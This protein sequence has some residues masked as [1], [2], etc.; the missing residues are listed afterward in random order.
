MQVKEGQDPISSVLGS[1]TSEKRSPLVRTGINPG[2]KSIPA[3]LTGSPAFYIPTPLGFTGLRYTLSPLSPSDAG[4][5]CNPVTTRYQSCRHAAV[6]R[7]SGR[8]RYSGRRQYS[9][10]SHPAGSTVDRTESLFEHL[11]G[12]CSGSTLVKMAHVLY[13]RGNRP[14]VDGPCPQSGISIPSSGQAARLASIGRRV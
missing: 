12:K 6:T 7:R 13:R 9:I 5:S 4:Q 11:A 1:F 10:D 14:L 3:E 8:G 2:V